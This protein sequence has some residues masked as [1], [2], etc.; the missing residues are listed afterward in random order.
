[1]GFLALLRGECIAVRSSHVCCAYV[2]V[3]EG[4]LF[5]RGARRP[6]TALSESRGGGSLAREATVIAV[7]PKLRLR[8]GPG[9]E[10]RTAAGDDPP[11]WRSGLRAGPPVRRAHPMMRPPPVTE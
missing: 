8:I 1:M 9:M 5:R 7:R 11:G 10:V 4:G 6:C 3:L 2:D